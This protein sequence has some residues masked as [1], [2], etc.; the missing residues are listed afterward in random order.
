[1]SRRTAARLA[2]SLCALSVVLTALALLLLALNLS[3]PDTHI[4]D[5]WFGNTLIVIDVS[6]GAIVASRRPCTLW[7]LYCLAQR[8][9]QCYCD[10]A[11]P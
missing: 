8:P 6:V 9:Y 11:G 2:W 4:F 7:V 10:C 5:W 3:Q 1:M